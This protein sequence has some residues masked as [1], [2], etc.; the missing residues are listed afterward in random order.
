MGPAWQ[1]GTGHPEWS[2]GY[3]GAKQCWPWCEEVTGPYFFPAWH[4]SVLAGLRATSERVQSGGSC[5][6]LVLT[7]HACFSSA[8]GFWSVPSWPRLA[9]KEEQPLSSEKCTP[10]D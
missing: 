10:G 4:S 3:A 6:G 2:H 9:L 1:V 5:P 8:C 7:L